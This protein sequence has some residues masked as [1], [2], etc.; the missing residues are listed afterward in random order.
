MRNQSFQGE[1]KGV[2]LLIHDNWAA[3]STEV[4]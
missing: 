3:L 2:H 1:K 4:D